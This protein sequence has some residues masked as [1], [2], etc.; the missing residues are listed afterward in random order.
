[1]NFGQIVVQPLSLLGRG[2]SLLRPETVL[3][4][5][6]HDQTGISYASIRDG[7]GWIFFQRLFVV[8]DG[9][10]DVLNVLLAAHCATAFQVEV[11]GLYIF[12]RMRQGPSGL[13]AG[14][15]ERQ[16]FHK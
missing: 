3:F 15:L 9:S 14:G 1:M 5:V 7:E 13:F 6:I 11:I 2:E 4:L 12:C 8:V 16:S 10:L